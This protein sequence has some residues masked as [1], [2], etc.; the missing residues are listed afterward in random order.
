MFFLGNFCPFL[1]YIVFLSCLL[2]EMII[3]F[4]A[5]YDF[6]TCFKQFRP[7]EIFMCNVLFNVRSSIRV[8]D[9]LNMNRDSQCQGKDSSQFSNMASHSL[10]G[11][12]CWLTKMYFEYF[13]CTFKCSFDVIAQNLC[14]FLGDFQ[15]CLKL[16]LAWPLNST[17]L[18]Q[19]IQH[20]N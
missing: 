18:T 13:Q 17:V 11:W 20:K 4:K 8:T 16:L 1:M 15:Q 6:L 12:E 19:C 7:M 3:I 5:A 9:V 10:L 14:L 2:W